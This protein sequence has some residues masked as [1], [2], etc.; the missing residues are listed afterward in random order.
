MAVASE[1]RTMTA[2]QRARLVGKQ[3][4]VGDVALELV[5]L[6]GALGDVYFMDL[7]VLHAAAPTPPAIQE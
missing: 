1:G 6:S 7:R 5:E 4:I 2:A 3:C